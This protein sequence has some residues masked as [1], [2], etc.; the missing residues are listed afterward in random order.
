MPA[1]ARPR[2]TR[3]RSTRIL[4]VLALIAATFAALLAPSSAETP[5]G[6]IP[7]TVSATGLTNVVDGQVAHIHVDAPTSSIFA[8]EARICL[9]SSTIDNNADFSPTQG[10]SCTPQANPLS[11]GSDGFVQVATAPPNSSAD[12]DFKLGKGTSSFDPGDGSTVTLTCDETHPCKLVL[13]LVVPASTALPAGQAFKSYPI[14]YAGSATTPGAPTAVSASAGDAQATLSWTAPASNGGSAITS[15]TAISSPGAKT[16]T[17]TTGPLSCTITGLTNGT[18]YTFT[19]KAHNAIGDGPSSSASTAVTPVSSDTGS[20]YHPLVPGRVLDSRAGATNVGPFSTPWSPGVAGI[21]DVQIGGLVGVPADATAVVLNVTV[22]NPTAGS[23]LQLWPTGSTQP[24]FGSSL[25]FAKDQIVPNAVTV[26]L[27]T[28]GKVRVFNAVGN[29]NVIIDV[30]GYYGTGAGDGFTAITPGR[31]LD[32]RSGAT[33]VGPFS[34][35]WSPGAA[36]IRDVQIG[37]LAGVPADADAVVLNVTVVNPTAGSFLQLWPTGSTQPVFGSSLNYQKDQIVPNQVTVKLGTGGKVRVFN[38]VG[39][40]N[41]IADVSGYYKSGSGK[42]FF[43]IVPGR[44]LDSR[45]GAT[46]VGAFSTP[47]SAGVAGIRDV[48]MGGLVGVP[49]DA[50]GVVL[51]VTIV[52]PSAGSFLQ[53]WPTG[54]TQPVFGS[55]LNFTTDQIVPNAVTVKLGTGGKVR[56]FNAVGSVNVIADVAG[57]F[58]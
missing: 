12:L 53:L 20:L 37:G 7:V 54:S 2:S 31:V 24:V 58:R 55:S 19:V 25:N 15:Y 52:N 50:D 26:K 36:G 22:V 8:V 21:R 46:N 10:L 13:K 16:C 29:V 49:A 45:S 23:F 9:G 6:D 3:T 35:P 30:S 14:N 33:N 57:Y 18:P 17:W 5:P 34:T 44:V 11:A 28:G 4:V 43:P 27:G 39:N 32:S 42:A 48:Q 51:N 1:A 47:W 56:V 38:A 41:V 40:V